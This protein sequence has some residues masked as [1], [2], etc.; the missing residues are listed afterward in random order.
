MESSKT[1]QGPLAPRSAE[2]TSPLP[3]VGRFTPPLQAETQSVRF[4]PDR[5]R[6]PKLLRQLEEKNPQP[7][8]SIVQ[9]TSRPATEFKLY[10]L[11]PKKGTNMEPPIVEPPVEQPPGTKHPTSGDP[12]KLK[13]MKKS[14]MG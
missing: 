11:K 10:Q 4:R 1:Y 12:K 5:P 8:R 6:Q 14:W 7:V 3:L 9:P 2:T 13:P